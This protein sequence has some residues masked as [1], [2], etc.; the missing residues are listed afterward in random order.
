MTVKRNFKV[1]VSGVRG[2]VG[3]T[4]P[5]VLVTEF[6]AAFGEYVG[7]GKVIVGRDTR[8]TGPMYERAVVAGLLSVGCQPVLIGV[9]PTPTVQMMVKE[10]SA[11]GGIAI[12]ASHNPVQWNALKFINAHS[13]FLS[14]AEADELLDVYNQ[15]GRAYAPEHEYRNIRYLANAFD[16]HQKKVFQAVDVDAIR[17]KKFRVAIDPGNGA[18]AYYTRSFLEEL[19]CEVIGIHEERDSVFRRKPEPVPENLGALT[20]LVKAEK[21]DIGFAQDPDADRLV[22]VDNAGVPVG[23]QTTLAIAVEHI[24]SQTQGPIVVNIQ[25]SS[26]IAEI[27]K[28]YHS[29]L[30]YANVGEINVTNQMLKHNAIIGGEG[31][32][33]GVIYP[34]IHPC[35][36]SFTGMALTLEMMAQQNATICDIVGAL[37]KTYFLNDK[38][39]CAAS[40]AFEVLRRLKFDYAQYK[41]NTQDGIRIDF[42]DGAWVIMRAS[43]TEPIVRIST[44]SKSRQR[45][46][47]LMDEFK[48]VIQSVTQG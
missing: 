37:P 6:A 4:L 11:N 41:P 48:D 44:E 15:P 1:S 23:E 43:N 33:G 29:P 9:V 5:P 47:E 19:G 24:L 8:P 25:T 31:G 30:T 35:R 10:Y 14:K 42:P 13:I 2:V 34:R 21:C 18:G 26:V 3:D 12:T 32:S 38:L 36:D 40:K 20:A 22:I 27:A 17:A 45:A 16:F 46:Q 39:P 7:R 28:K